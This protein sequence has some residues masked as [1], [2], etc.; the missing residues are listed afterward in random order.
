MLYYL[1]A[2]L[3]A[4][5]IQLLYNAQKLWSQNLGSAGFNK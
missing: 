3:Q 5:L 2:N 4:H 1:P